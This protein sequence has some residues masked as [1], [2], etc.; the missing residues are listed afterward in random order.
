MAIL[1]EILKAFTIETF[2]ALKEAENPDDAEEEKE[3]EKEESKQESKQEHMIKKITQ[4]LKERSDLAL[5]FRICRNPE[6]LD[7]LRELYMAHA[8]ELHAQMKAEGGHHHAHHHVDKV[9]IILTELVY[10]V[11]V[12]R[13]FT[14]FSCASCVPEAVLFLPIIRFV[15]VPLNSFIMLDSMKGTCVLSPCT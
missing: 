14:A 15:R 6:V 4:T 2:L 7:A 3:V 5:H 12:S 1:F 13:C 9:V 10:M 11:L 8:M